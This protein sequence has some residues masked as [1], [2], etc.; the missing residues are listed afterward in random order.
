[1]RIGFS[2]DL[3]E[4]LIPF[5]L[6]IMFIGLDVEVGSPSS[7]GRDIEL[8][9]A[10]SVWNISQRPVVTTCIK[11]HMHHYL[12]ISVIVPGL[13]LSCSLTTFSNAGKL[14]SALTICVSLCVS[15]GKTNK[16]A[17]RCYE[18][19]NE[20]PTFIFHVLGAFTKLQSVS[21]EC[22]PNCVHKLKISHI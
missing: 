10:T 14:L 21:L 12:N 8:A 9:K 3:E 6:E 11:Y 15:K 4:L 13:P 7:V 17:T 20:I 18:H 2:V 19:G 22:A 5:A 16:E 1:M